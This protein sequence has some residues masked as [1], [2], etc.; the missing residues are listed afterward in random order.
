MPYNIEPIPPADEINGSTA[1]PL[2]RVKRIIKLDEE[3]GT[4]SS[5]AAFLVTVAAEMFIQYLANQGYKG[6]QKD[7]RKNLQYK[8]L[9]NAVAALDTL[10]FLSDTIP[11][12][13][14]YKKIATERTKK[15]SGELGA[16]QMTL[17]GGRGQNGYG[18]INGKRKLSEEEEDEDMSGRRR[19]IPGSRGER[20]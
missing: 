20:S 16:G 8:D 4:C 6:A 1:L 11:R 10:E 13:V 19:G 15:T 18:N 2:T 14:P 3:I 17:N 9:A 12:T 5:S 7:R